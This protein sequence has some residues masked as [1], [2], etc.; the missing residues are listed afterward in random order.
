VTLVMSSTLR[1]AR[2][3]CPSPMHVQNKPCDGRGW[4][5]TPESGVELPLVPRYRFCL[6]C[7]CLQLHS[8][9]SPGQNKEICSRSYRHHGKVELFN[10]K[11]SFGLCSLHIFLGRMSEVITHKSGNASR[12]IVNRSAAAHSCLE[13]NG[14]PA[15]HSCI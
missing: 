13:T 8:I 11:I 15:C 3:V 5:H 4:R 9:P 6:R 1:R 12:L 2:P 7:G 10:L 14:M